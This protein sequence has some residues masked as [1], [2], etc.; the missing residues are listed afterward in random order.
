MMNCVS[1][2]PAARPDRGRAGDLLLR[3]LEALGPLSPADQALV[4]GLTVQFDTHPPGAEIYGEGGA[5]RK[6]RI[7]VSGWA[8]RTRVLPD[9][10]RQIFGFLIPGDAMGMCVR[11]Q[12]LALATSLA[13]TPLVTCDAS[14]LRDLLGGPSEEHPGLVSA[15]ILACSLDEA[16]LLDQVVRLGRQ[17][18]YERI[19]HMV[20]EG[21]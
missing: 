13:L 4:R 10:R 6:P 9:G 20:N 12:P 18:A 15:L 11:P 17:T 3:R 19:G 21:D 1:H 8:C 2:R 5:L 16:R 7:I 14:A